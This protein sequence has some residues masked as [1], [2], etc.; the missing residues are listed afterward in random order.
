L[1]PYALAVLKATID[2]VVDKTVGA[3]CARYRWDT[4]QV[5]PSFVP[6]GVVG[7]EERMRWVEEE[8]G[9]DT[10]FCARR[11]ALLETNWF[12]DRRASMDALFH[13]NFS[14]QWRQIY[15]NKELALQF[16]TTGNSSSRGHHGRARILRKW[17]P[18]MAW[19]YE[20][21]IRFHGAAMAVHAPKAL[22]QIRR[23]A[24][25]HNF[26]A[27]YRV[28]GVRIGWRYVRR[29]PTDIGFWP[30]LVAGAIMPALV[31]E[32]NE[33]RHSVRNIVGF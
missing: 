17:A 11:S 2:E 10:L 27:G 4:G 19:Q 16:A 3:V 24:A 5:T 13:L 22:Q 9:T 26:Y 12:R 1:E 15:L 29:A 18:D 31:S 28:E 25:L 23:Q 32:L 20:E 7:Y 21:I 6:R 8:G 30:I 14:R 33:W